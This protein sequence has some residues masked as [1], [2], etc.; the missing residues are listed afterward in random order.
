MNRR[1]REILWLPRAGGDARV[2]RATRAI[3]IGGGIAGVAAA[4]VLCERGVQVTLVERQQT[5]GGRA[6]GFPIRLATGEQVDMERG[7]HAFF[8]QYYNLRSLLRR[9]DPDLSSLQ[10]LE[11]YPILGPEGRVQNF[12]GL[13]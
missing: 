2:S 11:D 7:F 1:E 9:V 12:R 6:A 13:P 8:R 10:Q 4:A 5:L 3:V